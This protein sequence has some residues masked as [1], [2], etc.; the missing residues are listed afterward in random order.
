MYVLFSCYAVCIFIGKK[1]EKKNKTKKQQQNLKVG[2][3]WR[4]TRA[5][6]QEGRIIVA[7]DRELQ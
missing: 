2:E 7:D 6:G 3:G 4:G 1:T 5:E